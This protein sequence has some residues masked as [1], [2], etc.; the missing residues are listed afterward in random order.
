MLEL[1]GA[2]VLSRVRLWGSPKT[3]SCCWIVQLLSAMAVSVRCGEPSGAGVGRVAV[4]HQSVRARKVVLLTVAE[5]VGPMETVALKVE[6]SMVRL[7]GL[8]V[9]VETES[10][11][12]FRRVMSV[13]AFGCGPPMMWKAL[14]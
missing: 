12:Q 9:N 2:G 11:E 4:W 3:E 8:L 14:P 1:G 7:A 10:E 6:F 5:A 13:T